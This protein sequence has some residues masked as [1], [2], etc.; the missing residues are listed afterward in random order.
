[1][2]FKLKVYSKCFANYRGRDEFGNGYYE[3]KKNKKRWVIYSGKNEPTK[4]P[5][6]WQCWL[7][8]ETGI[9]GNKTHKQ[10]QRKHQNPDP[11]TVTNENR[12]P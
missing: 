5:A 10:K 9:L 11:R 7:Q 4:V 12:Q 2:T 3:H 1:M 8:Y 6:E